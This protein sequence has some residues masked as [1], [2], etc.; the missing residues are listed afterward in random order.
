MHHSLLRY[1]WNPTSSAALTYLCFSQVDLSEYDMT[2]YGPEN[3][4][5]PF[6]EL[7]CM[8]AAPPYVGDGPCCR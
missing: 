2:R 7:S 5:V 3:P 8:D 6:V 4:V 1:F